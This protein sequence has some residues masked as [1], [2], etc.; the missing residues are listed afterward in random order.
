[1]L[2][3]ESSTFYSPAT[4]SSEFGAGTNH[5][6][7]WAMLERTRLESNDVYVDCKQEKEADMEDGILVRSVKGNQQVESHLVSFPFRCLNMEV[8]VKLVENNNRLESE[9]AD[10]K[11]ESDKDVSIIVKPVNDDEDESYLLNLPLH[12]LGMVMEFSVGVEY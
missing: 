6:S 12:V 2:A 1:E 8:S 10:P 11:Q 3:T 9:N 5:V 7:A 4:T